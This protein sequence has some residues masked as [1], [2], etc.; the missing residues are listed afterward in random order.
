LR[1]HLCGGQDHSDDPREVS[2]WHGVAAVDI[3]PPPIN[4]LS[5]WCFLVET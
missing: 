2:R 3:P 5:D 1:L 4:K